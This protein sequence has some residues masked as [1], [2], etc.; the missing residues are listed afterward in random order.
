MPVECIL[1]AQYVWS[2][3]KKEEAAIL[4][5]KE[6]KITAAPKVSSNFWSK[7]KTKDTQLER[8]DSTL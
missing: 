6:E 4:T 8:A 3:P 2:I 7:V 5:G 1:V